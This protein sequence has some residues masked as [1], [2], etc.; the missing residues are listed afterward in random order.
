M[1]KFCRLLKVFLEKDHSIF[2]FKI[3][4][5]KKVLEILV[6]KNNQE[7]YIKDLHEENDHDKQSSRLSLKKKEGVQKFSAFGLIIYI[8]RTELLGNSLLLSCNSYYPI[9]NK[10]LKQII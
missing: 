6:Y 10:T 9:E 1:Q 4:L 7:R 8:G 5:M 3:G 2:L